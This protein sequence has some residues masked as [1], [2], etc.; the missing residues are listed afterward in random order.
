V[1]DTAL[2]PAQS[3]RA[4]ALRA[5]DGVLFSSDPAAR[6]SA[7]PEDD[8]R[9]LIRLAEW[10]LGATTAAAPDDEADPGL[11]R[12]VDDLNRER[13]ML[14]Q[15]LVDYH[16]V[17]PAI[18]FGDPVGA[19]LTRLGWLSE[20]VVEQVARPE[21]TVERDR[22]RREVADLTAVRDEQGERLIRQAE[23][24]VSARRRIAQLEQRDRG[25]EPVTTGP[26]RLADGLARELRDTP[27]PAGADGSWCPAWLDPDG[28]TCGAQM[29]CPMHPAE[30]MLPDSI[31]QLLDRN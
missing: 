7:S 11:R 29:P 21:V 28:T 17:S 18:A 30:R 16:D 26:D 3:A 15:R 23:Q 25:M 2:T 24:I 1:D 14:G 4:E 22:L 20:R 27:P 19:A 13:N 6:P 31:G 10:I 12:M 5:A 8:V 9:D